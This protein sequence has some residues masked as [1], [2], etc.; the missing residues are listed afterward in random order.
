VAV[1]TLVAAA[2]VARRTPPLPAEYGK[3]RCFWRSFIMFCLNISI[4]HPAKNHF[5]SCTSL[6]AFYQSAK[7]NKQWLAFFNYNASF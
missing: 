6:Y 7:S 5:V 4:S 1:Q 2:A 3:C